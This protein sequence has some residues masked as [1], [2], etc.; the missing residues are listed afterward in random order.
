[1]ALFPVH[2]S[3]GSGQWQTI[4]TVHPTKYVHT[5]QVMCSLTQSNS[6]NI[7]P[8]N[9]Q[10]PGI[11]PIS[12]IFY[13]ISNLMK[14]FI[15]TVWINWFNHEESLH[16]PRQ[17]SGLGMHKILWCTEHWNLNK[18]LASTCHTETPYWLCTTGKFASLL[19]RTFSNLHLSVQHLASLAI[20]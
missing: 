3:A 14:V 11:H 4:F 5:Y 18:W 15:A 7:M 17:H 13:S 20:F 2:N 16:V 10:S 6:T 8:H 1:M 12:Y 19:R 9:A